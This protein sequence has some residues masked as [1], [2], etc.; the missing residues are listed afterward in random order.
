ML[1]Q[2]SVKNFSHRLNKLAAVVFKS[3]SDQ[4]ALDALRL[5]KLRTALPH[6]LHTKLY[7]EEINEYTL[8]VERV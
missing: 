6:Y 1:P 8:A 3:I 7:G 5:E 4:K 2:E